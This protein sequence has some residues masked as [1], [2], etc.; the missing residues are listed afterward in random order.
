MQLT[1]MVRG[2]DG[3]EYGPVTLE[4]L[5]DWA[6]ESRLTAEQS[7]KRS[8][9]A[10]FA[11]ARDF[12]ELQTL[13]PSGAPATAG[14]ATLARSATAASA[15][16]AAVSHLKSGASWFYWIAALSL[17][18]SISAASGSSWRFIIG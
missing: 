8:D 11:P 3:K 15:N 14:P 5:N 18:N 13:F 6:R 4:Q 2:W 7:V 9:M 12:T 16:P 10:G 17:I 1:Y